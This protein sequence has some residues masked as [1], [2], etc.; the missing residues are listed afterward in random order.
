MPGRAYIG[1][2]G[3]RYSP[4]RGVFYPEGLKQRDE[5]AYIA[6]RYSTLEIN[7]SFYS[8]QRPEYYQRWFGETPDD[9]VFA[10]KGSRYITHMLRLERVETALANFFASGV[11]ALGHKLGPFLWQLPPTLRFDVDLLDGFLRLLPRTPAEA[12]E[13]AMRHDDRVRGRAH[14][15]IADIAPLRHAVEVRHAS[16]ATAAFIELLRSRDV[17]LVVAD[18]AGR[19]PL[20]EDVTS[21]F[22]YVRLHGDEELYASGYTDAALRDWA[23]RVDAWREGRTPSEPRLAAKPLRRAKRCDVY[24]YFD[25]DIKVHAPFDAAKLATLVGSSQRARRARSA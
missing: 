25:N 13:L 14:L 22:V 7:G 5:L 3:W 23:K 2:S 16:F 15:T 4:W 8:L 21:D 10:V 1:V 18:T 6:A 24:V 20:L 17:G 12:A 19:W 9:F 11:L